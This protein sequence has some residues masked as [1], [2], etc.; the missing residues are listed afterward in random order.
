MYETA[1]TL[2]QTTFPAT[3]HNNQPG[4]VILVRPDRKEDLFTAV[5]I[6]HHPIDAPILFAD[7]DRL[8]PETR[9]ALE[10][11]E[12]EGIAFDRNVQVIAVGDIS[13]RVVREVEVLGL[14]VRRLQGG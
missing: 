12:P 6:I 5:S 13:D 11:F 2:A 7:Q 1:V 3:S 4:A 10:R 8:P 14:A 9:A